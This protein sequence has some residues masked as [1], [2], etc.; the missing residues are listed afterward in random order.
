MLRIYR[1]MMSE[2]SYQIPT[3]CPKCDGEL[4]D[5]WDGEPLVVHLLANGAMTVF[6]VKGI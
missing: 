3:K 6:V 2:L 5:C 4:S 1:K